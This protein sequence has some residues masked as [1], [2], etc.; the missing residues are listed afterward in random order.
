MEFT[1]SSIRGWGPSLGGQGSGLEGHPQEQG[2]RVGEGQALEAP[3]LWAPFLRKDVLH[4]D[5][6]EPRKRRVWGPGKFN[7]REKQRK[8]SR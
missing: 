6:G 3:C 2:L 4:Q 7:P 8:S 5:L 1:R